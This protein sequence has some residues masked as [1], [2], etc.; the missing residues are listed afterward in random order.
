MQKFKFNEN[1]TEIG[2]PQANNLKPLK[3]LNPYLLQDSAMGKAAF[4]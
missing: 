2:T 4:Q 3:T 1:A